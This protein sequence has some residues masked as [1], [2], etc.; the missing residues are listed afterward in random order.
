M[1]ISLF[2][3]STAILLSGSAFA[4]SDS[5]CDIEHGWA[6]NCQPQPPAQQEQPAA[7]FTHSEPPPQAQ[8]KKPDP[9]EWLEKHQKDEKRARALMLM[10]PTMENVANYRREFVNPDL[11]KSTLVS[12]Y[13][14]RL[15]WTNPDLDYTTLRPVGT[16]AKR[17]WEA[18]R[19]DKI[20][21]ALTGLSD[22]Y[23]IFFLF[24]SNNRACSAYA[25]ILA[26]FAQKWHFNI[27]GISRDGKQLTTWPG[28]WQSDASGR[29]QQQ[30]G[31][32]R[33]PAPVLLLFQS[34]NKQHPQ[35]QVIPIGSGLLA[36]DE[37]EKRIYALTTV[38][39]GTDY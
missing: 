24:E 11:E 2:F 18:Q 17:E 20:K 15:T 23:G 31:I 4:A 5:L 32:S 6:W 13:W 34:P 10:E 26:D 8:P 12:D 29:F 39:P 7:Q 9:L 22:R 16:L 33:F 35:G 37:L 27:E 25:P 38:T 30:L 36:Q 19:Q 14:Q 28:S 3:C 1:K 21:Q